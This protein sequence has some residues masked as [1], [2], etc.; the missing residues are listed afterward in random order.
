[1]KIIQSQGFINRI[2]NFY[3]KLQ[4]SIRASL[5]S[6]WLKYTLPIAYITMVKDFLKIVQLG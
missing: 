2:L 3:Q 5:N 1:M 4:I 6:T